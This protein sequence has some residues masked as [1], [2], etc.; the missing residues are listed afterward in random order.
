MLRALGRDLIAVVSIARRFVIADNVEAET[1]ACQRQL[2]VFPAGSFF[3]SFFLQL[4]SFVLSLS[5]SLSPPPS[6]SR[7]LVR[8]SPEHPQPAHK[9]DPFLGQMR[10][11]APLPTAQIADGRG[12]RGKGQRDSHPAPAYP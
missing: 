1:G 9:A 12:G 5:L 3:Y 6:L 4:F 7:S 10:A 11:P 8:R 2:T